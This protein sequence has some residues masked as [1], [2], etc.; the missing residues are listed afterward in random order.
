MQHI[1]DSI[2]QDLRFTL[3]TLGRS[4]GFAAAAILCLALGIG[5]NTAVFSVLN[6]LLFKRLPVPEAGKVTRVANVRFSYLDFQDLRPALSSFQHAAATTFWET[7]IDT[8]GGNE[9]VLGEAVT[10]EY[11]AMLQIRPVLGRWFHESEDAVVISHRVWQRHFSGDPAV[12]G[13]RL[14]MERAWYTVAGVLPDSFRGLRAPTLTSVWAPVRQLSHHQ[15]MAS[16][17]HNRARATFH[18]FGRLSGGATPAQAQTEMNAA[19]ARL[20]PDRVKSRALE[21]ALVEVVEGISVPAIRRMLPALA[22]LTLGTVAI[23]LLIACINVANL[24]L[25]RAVARRREISVRLALG[26]GR[27]RILQQ[28]LTE[29]LVLSLA[30]GLLGLLFGTWVSRL[31]QSTVPQQPLFLVTLDVSMDGRVLLFTV[32][33]SCIAALLFGLS[34]AAESARI[35]LTPALKGMAATSTRSRRLDIRSVY[36]VGQVAL[37]LLLLIVS[38][39]FVRGLRNAM[40]IDPGFRPEHLA[41]ALLYVSEPEYNATTGRQLYEKV[42]E[43][44]RQMPGVRSAAMS[45]TLPTMFMD[46]DC[47]SIPGSSDAARIGSNT[48]SPQYF[49]TM[50]IRLLAG[51]DFGIRDTPATQHVIIINETLAR[52][53]FKDRNPLGAG[54]Q[55]GCGETKTAAQ[56]AGIVRDSTY[57]TLGEPPKPYFYRPYAQRYAGLMA[58]IVDTP[59]DPSAVLTPLRRELEGM[60]S[61]MR[62]YGM[63]TMRERLEESLGVARWQAQAFGFFG[64]LALLLASLGLYGVLSYLVSA[65]TREIGIRMAVGAAERDVVRMVLLHSLRLTAIGIVIGLVLSTGVSR[66]L[67]SLLFGLSPTDTVTFGAACLLWLTVALAATYLPARRATRVQPSIALRYD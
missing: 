55:L 44:V 39:L 64:L 54:V 27:A 57:D 35:D 4:P 6:D 56:I 66:L 53:Y 37:S 32:L 65:R 7:A 36:I 5:V 3:R 20:W 10:P 25:A 47:L 2:A 8:E 41:T 67:R 17:I 50:S 12:I 26:A 42:L 48:V 49:Q 21:P 59:M 1:I 31:L 61:G 29:S 38:G 13:K 43:R 40:H 51:R 58:L 60:K 52:R 62:I 30:G 23:V 18:L 9:L 14:R 45:Y 33:V 28:V 16:I 19:V 34:P 46:N 24:L 11:G 63:L 15:V 22:A